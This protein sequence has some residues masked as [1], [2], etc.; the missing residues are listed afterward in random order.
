MENKSVLNDLSV[1]MVLPLNKKGDATKRTNYRG[2]SILSV[3]SKIY[4]IILE[5]KLRAVLEPTVDDN[6]PRFRPGRGTTERTSGKDLA[7]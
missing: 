5:K 7:I 6:Q 1:A 2:I 3:P 4:E